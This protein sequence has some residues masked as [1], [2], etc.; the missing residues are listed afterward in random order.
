MNEMQPLDES[1][2]LEDAP[3]ARTPTRRE[4]TKQVEITVTVRAD[5][6]LGWTVHPDPARTYVEDKSKTLVWRLSGKDADGKPI[7]A[8]RLFFCSPDEACASPPPGPRGEDGIKFDDVDKGRN[9]WI[10]DEKK[11]EIDRRLQSEDH[12]CRPDGP[13]GGLRAYKWTLNPV[14]LVG[15]ESLGDDKLRLKYDV[16]IVLDGQCHVLDP[17][18]EMEDP[19]E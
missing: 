8:S 13:V 6:S 9:P 10:S 3:R 12:R 2:G 19:P 16:R 14:K 15:Q 5:G 18:E 7:P 11:Q 4:E 1:G 17:E